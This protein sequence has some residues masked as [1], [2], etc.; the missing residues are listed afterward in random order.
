MSSTPG[1]LHILVVGATGLVGSH[2]IKE[3]QTSG[4]VG[5]I[6]V[7]ARRSAPY[8]QAFDKVHAII[9][10]DSL[11]WS[12][13]IQGSEQIDMVF[14]A[15]GTTV[16]D[17]GGMSRQRRVDYDLN[18]IVAHQCKL[19]GAKVFVLVSAFNNLLVT[20]TLPYFALKQQIEDAIT[21]LHYDSTII[22][23]PGPL[24]G[25]RSHVKPNK[26]MRSILSTFVADYTYDTPFSCLVGGTVKAQEVA[27][28]AM[29]LLETNQQLVSIKVLSSREIFLLSRAI[30]SL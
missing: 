23:R 9:E 29:F 7:L 8:F 19:K 1:S 12:K 10:P 26:T 21:F 25:D 20:K 18:L 16:G 4:L 17:A 22:L 24:V 28:A 15:L 11:L 30:D 3:A 14:S 2:F 6:T 5:K 27:E 13:W